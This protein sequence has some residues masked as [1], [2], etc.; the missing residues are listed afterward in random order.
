MN[1]SIYE[2]WKVERP[3]MDKLKMIREVSIHDHEAEDMNHDAEITGIMYVKK[4]EVKSG[5]SAG[6]NEDDLK[7]ELWAKINAMD[8]EKKPHHA[9][10]VAKLEAFIEANSKP[11]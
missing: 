7:A 1:P 3:S 9:S 6:G 11:E 4:G 5:N 8:V 10:G 2:V